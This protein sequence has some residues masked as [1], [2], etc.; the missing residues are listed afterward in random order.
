M[1]FR[2]K[3]IDTKTSEDEWDL[4]TSI[5]KFEG[6]GYDIFRDAYTFATI[7]GCEHAYRD[8]EDP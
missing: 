8:I 3:I 6:N 4:R 7:S 1:Q 2:A 5:C